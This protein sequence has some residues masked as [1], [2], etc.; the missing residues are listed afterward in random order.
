MNETPN[1]RADTSEFEFEALREAKN[2][3]AALVKEFRA[4]LKGNVL[5]VGAGIGQFT[6]MLIRLPEIRKLVSIEPD[7]AFCA[8]LQTAFP[9]LSIIQG[10]SSHLELRQSWNTIVSVNV[11]EH[12]EDDQGEL[13]RYYDLLEG[14][15]GALC[16]FVPARRE[17]YAPLDRDFG[18]FRRYTRNSLLK[19]LEAAGFQPLRLRYFN[20]VGYFAWWLNFCLLKKR[21]F[22]REAVIVFDRFIFPP[23]YAFESLVLHPLI[24]QSLL[25]IARTT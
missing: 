22:N 5:E 20:F 11:L 13:K 25:A 24:G 19:K 3:R 10:T 17:I 2:Y 23:F 21:R 8:R 18:H 12:I 14:K 6:Q 1:L 4:F 16:L 7:S 9:D 15:K